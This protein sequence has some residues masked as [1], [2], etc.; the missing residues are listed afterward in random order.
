M[1]EGGRVRRPS[2]TKVL[3]ESW[4]PRNYTGEIVI[5]LGDEESD[6][7]E[8]FDSV[9]VAATLNTPQR[10]PLRKPAHSFV[11]WFE[12]EPPNRV[13]ASEEL[14]MKINRGLLLFAKA[15]AECSIR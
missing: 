9:T 7:R 3:N 5:V 15:Q 11:P 2:R 14:A 12:V 8:H 6:A 10:L 1:C 13:V 4:G